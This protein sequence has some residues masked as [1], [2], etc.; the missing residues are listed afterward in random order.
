[1][2]FLSSTRYNVEEYIS[3]DQAIAAQMMELKSTYD[4]IVRRAK[5]IKKIKFFNKISGK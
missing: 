2:K 5:N 3:F 1:M 4:E